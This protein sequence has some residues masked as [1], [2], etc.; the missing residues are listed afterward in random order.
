MGG[1]AGDSDLY[2]RLIE[3]SFVFETWFAW[4]SAV[5][6]QPIKNDIAITNR[7]INADYVQGQALH[8]RIKREPMKMEAF[9]RVCEHF[10][11]ARDPPYYEYNATGSPAVQG[12]AA[13]GR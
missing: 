2:A 3:S 8:R 7:L 9:M 10:E 1:I 13:T 4:V 12:N 11:E 6:E 5:G